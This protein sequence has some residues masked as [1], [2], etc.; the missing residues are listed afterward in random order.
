MGNAF[1]KYGN[2]PKIEYIHARG[3]RVVP[4][5]IFQNNL[6]HKKTNLADH[7]QHCDELVPLMKETLDAL[8]TITERIEINKL[9]KGVQDEIE[10]A[11]NVLTDIRETLKSD[12]PKVA[13]ETRELKLERSPNPIREA[14]RLL[15][16][17]SEKFRA[18]PDEINQ[19]LVENLRTQ[20]DQL[21]NN[22][23]DLAKELDGL[24]EKVDVFLQEMDEISKILSAACKS[25]EPIDFAKIDNLEKAENLLSS[26]EG[27]NKDKEKIENNLNEARKNLENIS[28]SLPRPFREEQ[29]EQILAFAS[30]LSSKS[31][32]MEK[33]KKQLAQARAAHKMK[34]RINSAIEEI[35]IMEDELAQVDENG[36]K[37]FI[38]S[39]RDSKKQ[40]ELHERLCQDYKEQQTAVLSEILELEKPLA[41]DSSE[42]CNKIIG[43]TT[44][45]FKEKIK[46]SFSFPAKI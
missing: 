40:N 32:K 13:I 37:R 42:I 43:P 14:K 33:L 11:R 21:A 20:I 16:N 45:N 36:Q 28:T 44:E 7:E 1:S 23:K 3:F 35:E 24:P 31:S 25:D 22:E 41:G 8:L 9:V 27:P 10:K 6:S 12:G 26:W 46:V 30:S 2:Y 29:E 5:K 34:N 17:V 39:V 38:D 15:E 4:K 18:E 19:R